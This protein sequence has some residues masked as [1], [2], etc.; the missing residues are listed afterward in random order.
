VAYGLTVDGSDN[1]Q[2]YAWSSNVGWVDFAPASDNTTYPG[3]GYPTTPCQGVKKLGSDLVGWARIVSIKEALAF[4]NSGNWEGWVKLSPS[5]NGGV[6]ID[7]SGNWTGYAWSNELGWINFNGTSSVIPPP[8]PPPTEI[9]D[10]GIDDDGDGLI[11]TADPDCPLNP[12]C[13]F[14][15]DDDNDG[16][17][18][19]NDPDCTLPFVVS[20]TPSATTIN[21]NQPITFSGAI[22]SFSTGPY[23]YHWSMPGAFPSS[24]STKDVTVIYAGEGTFTANLIVHD[25]S[26]PVKTASASCTVNVS[27]GFNEQETDPF[28]PFF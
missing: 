7:A 1:V 11:D 5:Y 20:C 13:V 26:I 2:G 14:G 22:L 28:F 3:C 21:A 4:D 17:P 15:G 9:C 24:A 12:M 23:A 10:N 6:S 25:S 27:D 8:P 18:N 16:I 19:E